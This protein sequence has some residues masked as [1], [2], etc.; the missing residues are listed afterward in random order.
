[1]Y[2]GNAVFLEI[3]NLIH[4][5]FNAGFLHIFWILAV[6]CDHI[7]HFY[8]NRRAGQ[9]HTRTELL[10]RCHWHN[11]CMHRNI[12]ARFLQFIHKRIKCVIIKKHLCDQTVQSQ[13][14][15]LF[16]MLDV[17]FL[18]LRLRVY[19]WIAGTRDKEIS[20]FLD[21]WNQISCI[22]KIALVEFLL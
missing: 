7:T 8:R 4:G 19:L 22:L 18:I 11:T 12:N 3:Q 6:L 14:Y 1:M 17:L 16:Q 13:I 5:I 9:R 10:C 21:L 2:A 20:I 15:L